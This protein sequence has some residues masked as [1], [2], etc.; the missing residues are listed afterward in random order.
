MHFCIA[1]DFDKNLQ[2]LKKFEWFVLVPLASRPAQEMD[3]FQ[4]R[5][6]LHQRPGPKKLMCQKLMHFVCSLLRGSYKHVSLD[7]PCQEKM[8]VC[9]PKNTC[10]TGQQL[11]TCSRRSWD[12]CVMQRCACTTHRSCTFRCR[13]HYDF[14]SLDK[15]A[16]GFVCRLKGTS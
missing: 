16:L 1:E 14:A 4:K 10:F 8:S 6:T 2:I 3:E 13:V 5:K 12:F 7:P 11:V 9:Q 15:I